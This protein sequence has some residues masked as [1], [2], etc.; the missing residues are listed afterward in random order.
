MPTMTDDNKLLPP[1]E[2]PASLSAGGPAPPEP[3]DAR[4]DTPRTDAMKETGPECGA[5]PAGAGDCGR[6]PQSGEGV[7]PAPVSTRVV[8]ALPRGHFRLALCLAGEHHLAVGDRVVISGPAGKGLAEIRD[9]AAVLP[10]HPADL[11]RILRKAAP[12]D[13]ARDEENR[14]LEEQAFEYGENR[15]ADL[16]LPMKLVRVD[17]SFDRSRAIF[18]FTSEKRV[19]FRELVRDLARAFHC[20]IEMRQIGIRDE[21]RLLGGIGPCGLG[22]CCTSFLRE[23]APISVKMAKDQNVIL[24]PGKISGGCGRLLCC[25]GYESRAYEEFARQLPKIGKKVE[26]PEGKVKVKGWDIFART[27]TLEMPDGKTATMTVEEFKEKLP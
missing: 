26:L 6:A 21:A 15:I 16:G 12:D 7:R 4:K 11:P 27:V 20:R 9:V 22:Y 18:S 10:V 19:D 13:L 5:C 2:V 8:R 14:K 23:F 1:G 24:N 17:Y 25:L 3:Q